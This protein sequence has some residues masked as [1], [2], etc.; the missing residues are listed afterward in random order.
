MLTISSLVLVD[1]QVQY[2]SHSARAVTWLNAFQEF[3]GLPTAHHAAFPADAGVV[4]VSLQHESIFISTLIIELFLI[5][6]IARGS[7]VTYY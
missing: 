3:A 2:R 7:V 4:Q 5:E 6:S 1:Q